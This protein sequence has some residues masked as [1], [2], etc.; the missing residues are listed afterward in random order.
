MSPLRPPDMVLCEL[1]MP[2]EYGLEL[3]WTSKYSVQG[4]G[5]GVLGVGQVYGFL[6]HVSRPVA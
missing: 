4:F 3:P 6:G 5:I 1:E 2:L